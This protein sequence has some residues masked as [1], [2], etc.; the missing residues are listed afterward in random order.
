MARM[1]LEEK[2]GQM[3]QFVGFNYLS[4]SSA[5]MSA[6]EVLNSD[7]DA[8]Y[9]D[10]QV[11]DIAQMVVDGKIGSFLHVLSAEEANQLQSL[12]QK[13]RLKIPLLIGIDAIHGN[14]MVTG[15]TVYPSPITM[16]ASFSNELAYRI[17]RETALE[18]RATGS[19]WAFSPNVDVLRDPRWGRVGETFG[20]D[21]FLVGSLG[22]SMIEGYQ[23]EDFTGSDKVIACAKHLVAG[24]EPSNG[25]NVSEMD[26][27][28][29]TLREIFMKPFK[30]AVDAGVFTLMAAHNEVNGIPAHMHK[31]IMTDIVREEYGFK[32]FYVSDWLDIERLELLHNVAAD[33]KEAVLLSVDAG[34]DMHMHGPHFL[35]AVQALV[36]SGDL[37]EARVDAACAKILEAKFRLGLF[38]QPFVEIDAVEDRIFTEAHRATAL[39]AARQS[40]ILLENDGLLPLTK[41]SKK[42]ILVTGPNAN[43]HTQLGDWVMNQPSDKVITVFEGMQALAPKMGYD[44]DLHAFNP[45]AALIEDA[46]IEQAVQ[47]VHGYDYI[48]LAVGDNS[49]RYQWKE[50]TAGENLARSDINLVG[51]QLDLVQALH[52]TGVPL[53]LVYL[54]GKPLA[55]PWIAENLSAVIAAG[56]PGSMG[57]QAIAEIIMGEVNPSGKTPLTT[58]RSVGQL[59]MVYNH[60]P[61]QYA[62]QYA[63]G[64]TTPL[65]PF[66]YGLSYSDFEYSDLEIGKVELEESDA[67]RLSVKIENKTAIEG[68][69][70]VQVYFRD[71]VSSVT[72]PVKELVAYRRVD[73]AGNET[74]TVHFEIPV[75][76]LAFYDL[77]MQRCVEP[78][79]F[80]FM[81]GASSDD[82][83]LIRKSI[84][85]DRRYDF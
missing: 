74:E 25:L 67:I 37:P 23:M 43:N 33:F 80:E 38:E 72:R 64:A 18:M 4:Q 28:D 42:R 24:S 69:E 53:V 10:L 54:S 26:V 73:L 22:K 85:L 34:I 52:R 40:I 78:G 59:R 6:E 16:A 81:V 20:E 84:H 11:K 50:R 29:R 57:G 36:T 71:Q 14:A 61:S 82:S 17:A 9:E 31:E 47:A 60:K 44:V 1:S 83:D 66:G 30:T 77:K 51:R 7:S 46:D 35:E 5:E 12:A 45:R 3:C 19:H 32:G 49:L 70:I 68:T 79:A 56:E 76:R 41:S 13:S 2:I 65:Y 15:T 8:R 58:P 21:P 39:E 55:E 62:K 27:S 63:F 75:E 48:V